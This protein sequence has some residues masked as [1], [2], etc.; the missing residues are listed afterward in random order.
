M[1][2]SLASI[3]PAFVQS[4]INIKY[5]Q[6]GVQVKFYVN[7]TGCEGSEPLT[8]KWTLEG[9]DGTT[10]SNTVSV[11]IDH[12]KYLTKIV[13]SL[14]VAHFNSGFSDHAGRKDGV[15]QAKLMD[16]SWMPA[17]KIADVIQWN[18]P[19]VLSLQEFDHSWI[20]N[21]HW[22]SSATSQMVADF[23]R[24]F[25]A[26]PQGNGNRP[27]YY[28]HV[29]VAPC[30]TGVQTGYDLNKN[31]NIGDPG[32]AHGYG[33]F[34]G[35]FSMV[36]LSKFSLDTKNIRTFQHFL[37]TDM[38]GAYLPVNPA[39]GEMYYTQDK[40]SVLRLS[41]KSHWDIPLK[42]GG[43][44]IIHVLQSHPTP[45]VFDDGTATEYP[46]TKAIVDW[47]GFKNNNEIRFWTDY[48][49]YTKLSYIYDDNEWVSAGNTMPNHPRGGLKK[50]ERFIIIGD[51]NCD[52]VDGDATGALEQIP[53]T[54]NNRDTKT[55]P[56]GLHVDYVLPSMVGLEMVNAYVHWPMKKDVEAYLL[57]ASDHL[58]MVV[59]DV[60]A[61]STIL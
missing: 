46:P 24:N 54:Y 44:E 35:A 29:F 56:W 26:V 7:T 51:Q 61:S 43:N 52:P 37:W 4:S 60:K 50:Y 33:D 23:Q 20:D 57:D 34:P 47:N 59:V 6:T 27:V 31:G 14:R 18:N 17:K 38:P 48:I 40:L 36:L 5:E 32:D 22:N 21:D 45:P 42:V 39:T 9:N 15:L 12:Y 55:V 10:E 1:K 53:A 41:S 2:I 8:Y 49:D 25:L 58:M 11:E 30:N 13:G 16:P 19:D 3:L 28:E